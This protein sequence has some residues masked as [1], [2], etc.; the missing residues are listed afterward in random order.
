MTVCN[1]RHDV[2]HASQHQR[3]RS[4]NSTSMESSAS[5]LDLAS[6]CISKTALSIILYAVRLLQACADLPEA[7]GSC[8]AWRGTKPSMIAVVAVACLSRP[9]A[10][11]IV[12][13]CTAIAPA[14]ALLPPNGDESNAEHCPTPPVGWVA[15]ED[16]TLHPP[17]GPST[18]PGGPASRR[19]PGS[20]V[21]ICDAHHGI[22]HESQS[23]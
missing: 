23:Q 5:R 18:G 19:V 1:A 13:Q 21:T 22:N 12:Q 10:I 17:V 7:A 2:G 4:S 8:A 11:R 15:D 14:A 20:P 16:S 6:Q 9:G 3:F